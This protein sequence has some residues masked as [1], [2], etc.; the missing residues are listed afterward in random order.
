MIKV[1]IPAGAMRIGEKAVTEMSI[2]ENTVG[3]Y[4]DAEE[5]RL[6]GLSA[7]VFLLARQVKAVDGLEMAVSVEMLRNLPM[8]VLNQLEQASAALQGAGEITL[9]ERLGAKGQKA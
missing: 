7:G 3:D 6:E 1:T 4:L 5:Q 2:G 9:G 8:T